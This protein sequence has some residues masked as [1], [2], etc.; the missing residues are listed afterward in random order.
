METVIFGPGGEP[1]YMPDESM[2][3]ADI[4]RA[5]QI[6]ALTAIQAIVP[7]ARLQNRVSYPDC[8]SARRIARRSAR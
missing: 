4:E 1:V 2:E 6:N 5:A 7:G 3:I 8:C